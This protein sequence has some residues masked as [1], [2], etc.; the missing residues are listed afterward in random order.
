M[1]GELRFTI[2]NLERR[3]IIRT[4]ATKKVIEEKAGGN[5]LGLIQLF[6][7]SQS[8][9]LDTTIAFMFHSAVFG[10]HADNKPVDFTELD[11]YDW[12]DKTGGYSGELFKTFQAELFE[13]QGLKRV[14]NPEEEEQSEEVKADEKKN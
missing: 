12:I 9:L 8:S 3:F 1:N 6:T 5:V 10:A 4:Y 7:E 13:S 11:M 2:D 14:D